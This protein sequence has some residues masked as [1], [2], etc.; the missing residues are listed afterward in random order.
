MRK[1]FFYDKIL[2]MRQ[3]KGEIIL[4]FTSLIWGL[5]F[6]FQSEAANYI[7]PYTFN[8]LRFLL[9]AISLLPLMGFNRHNIDLKKC[10]RIGII[11]GTCIG[12]AS[13]LQQFAIGYTSAGKAGFLTSLY[14]VMVPIIAFLIYRQKPSKYVVISIFV[15]VIGLYFLC[16]ETSFV[17]ET[18]DFALIIC[19][20]FFAMQIIIVG[21]YARD[22]NSVLLSLIQY[23]VAGLL[24]LVLAL[25]FE[26]IDINAISN[27]S[28][29]ILYTGIF[30]TGVAYTLQIVGQRYTDP[31]IASLLMSLESVIAAIA[32]YFILH[33]ALS[34]R[35]LWG[36]ILMFIAVILSQMKG[37]KK[38]ENI[39]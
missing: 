11:L 21:K 13:N 34:Q 7:G 20:F 28:I 24:S 5:A 16:G 18:V 32:G 8:G 39:D 37:R 25:F 17:L 3:L 26:E 27:A 14:M 2:L 12:I 19:A 35:E 4:L 36:C 9:G 15:A 29:A 30:S 6:I 31:T 10:L 1:K 22:V 23:I 38:N 33:E